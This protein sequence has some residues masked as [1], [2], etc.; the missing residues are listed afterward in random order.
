MKYLHASLLGGD[1]KPVSAVVIADGDVI[2]IELSDQYM[3]VWLTD[4][5]LNV[6]FYE[7]APP[8]PVPPPV[9]KGVKR[10]SRKKKEEVENVQLDSKLGREPSE[11]P[12]WG[13]D[14]GFPN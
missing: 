1:G 8:E 2:K 3:V 4:G 12:A 11:A 13:L 7:I 14:G 9:L 5:D 10:H 6:E